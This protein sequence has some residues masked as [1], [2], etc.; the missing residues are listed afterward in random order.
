MIIEN[1]VFG[2][3]ILIENVPLKINWQQ[4]KN[5][6]TTDILIIICILLQTTNIKVVCMLLNIH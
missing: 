6:N 4:Y 5:K 3:T 2:M 1:E